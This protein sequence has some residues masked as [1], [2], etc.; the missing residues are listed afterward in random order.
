MAPKYT[1]ARIVFKWCRSAAR[2]ERRYARVTRGQNKPVSAKK[3]EGKSKLGIFTMNEFTVRAF[4]F[5][6]VGILPL[7]I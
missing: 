2:R 6:R 4:V 3:L 1:N 5:S 7:G